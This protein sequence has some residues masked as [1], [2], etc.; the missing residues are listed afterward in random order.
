MSEGGALIAG[1]NGNVSFHFKSARGANYRKYGILDDSLIKHSFTHNKQSFIKTFIQRG[2]IVGLVFS[3]VL[4][5][6]T[7]RFVGSSVSPSVRRSVGLFVRPSV[8]RSIRPSIRQSV[9]PSHFTFFGFAVFGL[10][11]R[12]QMIEWP[13]IQPLPTRMRLG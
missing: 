7:T 11:A 13:Q 4:R 6:S 1:W 12:A 5:D 8:R 3:R 2:R 10:T 9:R